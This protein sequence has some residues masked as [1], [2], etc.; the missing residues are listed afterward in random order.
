MR[1]YLL[2][3]KSNR[4]S[5]LIRGG[6]VLFF[7]IGIFG[8]NN[9][10]AKEA[11]SDVDSQWQ[12]HNSQIH[13][14]E[15]KQ[16]E[17]SK[18]IFLQPS[19]TKHGENITLPDEVNSFF[20]KR[21]VLEG[22][23]AEQFR[24]AQKML[25]QYA[26]RRIGIEGI[27]LIVKRLTDSF[28]ERGYITTRIDVAQQ[29][30]SGGELHLRVIPGRIGSIRF[31]DS[32]YR[33]NWQNAF[34]TG[35]GRI[36][37]LRDLEQGMEQMQRLASQVVDMKIVAGGKLGE[38]D[39]VISVKQSKPWQIVQTFDNSGVK[40]TG[41]LQAYT[42]V[43][44]DNL[45][46][47]NDIFNISYNKDTEREDSKL[48]TNGNNISFSIPYGNST[49]SIISNRYLYHETIQGYN[50]ILYSGKNQSLEYCVS[51]LVHRDQNSK[52]NLEF[53]I[54]KGLRKNFINDTEVEVQRQK[55]TAA[56]VGI[57][58]RQIIGQT[59]SDMHV[60]YQWGTP[61]F[62]AQIDPE[63]DTSN[64]PTTR[65]KLWTFDM[66][67]IKPVLLGK[68]QG[69]YTASLHAQY[70][71]NSLYGSEYISIG[72]RYTVRGFDGEQTLSGERGYFWRNE[73]SVPLGKRGQEIYLGMD[74]GQVFGSGTQSLK[75]N[76]LAGMVMGLRGGSHR[77]EYDVFI[78]TSLKKPDGFV[79]AKITVGF[80]LA[81]RI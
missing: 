47:V 7:C 78:G 43:S 50:P 17:Q 79:T 52:T 15:R 29:D 10:W 70:T 28:I 2:E 74:Y 33:G 56:K 6:V 14:E 41:K 73:L 66:N 55:T 21:I 61:W 42:N 48:G 12:N 69:R 54:I 39:V 81:Y 63:G 13:A 72:N 24:W 62:G 3:E 60:A 31:Q 64:Q 9:A 1:R 30:L 32:K 49:F 19:V 18:D 75:G 46:G 27:K 76:F 59:L 25:N 67:N 71:T 51:Q 36:L 68:I 45:L 35:P 4:N 77:A 38:S 58:R 34:P 80:Q 40:A 8:V 23:S 5:L 53:S 11:T 37:N 22:N 20:V 44:L 65:Y 26:G 57:G 16:R